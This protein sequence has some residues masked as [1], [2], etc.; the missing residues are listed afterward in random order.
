[1]PD[2][3]L[4][5]IKSK[6]YPDIKKVIDYID[7]A[8]DS[9]ETVRDFRPAV[10]LMKR[11]MIVNTRMRGFVA[12]RK[13]AVN[14]YSWEI[15]GNDAKVVELA[16][17]RLKPTIEKIK[18]KFWEACGF[19][20]F[21]IKCAWSEL[22]EIGQTPSIEFLKALELDAYEDYF[23]LVTADGKR[24]KLEKSNAYMLM[25]E[26]S[27][28]LGCVFTEMFR[29]AAI[30]ELQNFIKKLKGILQIVNTGGAD[31]DK[32]AGE[33]A[34]MAVS[35]NFM[36]TDDQLEVKFNTITGSVGTAFKDTIDS[37][38]NDIAIGIL[39]QANTSELPSSGGSRAALLVM[40]LVS[41][42]IHITEAEL[43]QRFIN[44]Q[45][46]VHDAQLN[47]GTAPSYEFRVKF[48]EDKNLEQ[49]SSAIAM[50]MDTG[51]PFVE[52]E[53]Y[54]IAGLRVPSKTDVVV[55]KQSGF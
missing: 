2:Y 3:K 21:G 45:L 37:L 6:V 52:D 44:E 48:E 42:D 40:M 49:I 25:S 22:P 18:S 26:D 54:K 16:T 41:Y 12:K 29:W 50:L 13:T 27:Y 8:L 17:R 30:Q 9:D 1:M 23:A 24:T 5:D 47:Y 46:L 15:R 20:R 10:A 14:S 32:A 31:N 38:N 55:Q 33:A 4:P 43:L 39:G 34:Q 7:K 19:G 53:I 11:M 35:N 28:L 51:L 36:I